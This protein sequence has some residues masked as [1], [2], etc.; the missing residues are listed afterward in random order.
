LLEGPI[1]PAPELTG[2]AADVWAVQLDLYE[3]FTTKDRPR[4]DRHIAVDG[5]MWDS[6]YEPLIFGLAGLNEV[7][8]MRPTGPDAVQPVALEPSDPVVTV[9]NDFAVSRHMLTVTFDDPAT[10]PERVRVTGVWRLLEG[11]W[12]N[13]HNHEDVLP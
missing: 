11:E 7:R 9:W 5:T 4:I 2:A 8:A 3:G 6:E 13:V 1:V 10:R 12:I